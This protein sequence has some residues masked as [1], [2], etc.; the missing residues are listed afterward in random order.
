MEQF[1]K[2]PRWGQFV[3]ILIVGG[4][5]CTAAW[6]YPLSDWKSTME[7]RIVQSAEL[8]AQIRQGKEAQRR[9]DELNRQ[10]DLIRRDLDVLK[11]II[12]VDPET[13]KLLR[14]FQTYARDQNLNIAAISPSAIVPKELYS[15]QAYKMT[16]GGGYH[17]VALFFDKIAHMRRIVNV[18]GLEMQAS[19]GKGQTVTA[20]FNAMVY[21]QNPAA[22]QALEKKS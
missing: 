21:M 7:S 16:V 17:D 5:I 15:E 19:T 20:N 14:V 18:T 9:V 4:L 8:D 3:A 10:I 1:A 6:F 11:S 12:P 22:F 2:L 13:G